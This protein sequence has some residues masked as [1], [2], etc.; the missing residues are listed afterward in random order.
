[1]LIILNNK[2]NFNKDEFLNYNKSLVELEDIE[3][4]TLVLCPSTIHIPNFKLKNI[5]LGAQNVS[6]TEYGAYTG[7]VS[8]PQLKSYNVK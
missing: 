5:I 7:E 2:C 8:A 4:N 1:M 6:T 3:K